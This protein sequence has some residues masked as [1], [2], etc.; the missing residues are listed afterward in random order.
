MNA[1]ALLAVLAFAGLMLV[2][3]GGL[4]LGAVRSYRRGELA[5]EGIKLLRWA[6]LGQL[7]IYL[8]LAATAFLD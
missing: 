5:F 6:L 1:A 2:I 4:Y 3:F 7:A 8:L